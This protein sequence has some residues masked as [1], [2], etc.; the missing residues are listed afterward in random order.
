MRLKLSRLRP[1]QVKP[2]PRMNVSPATIRHAAGHDTPLATSSAMAACRSKT[3][4][5]TRKSAPAARRPP[6]ESA[7]SSEKRCREKRRPRQ[8]AQQSDAGLVS[9]NSKP[10]GHDRGVAARWNQ[11]SYL[12]L[13][14]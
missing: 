5:T 10:R 11:S 12:P 13:V 7:A 1:Y 8:D 4:V 2:A 14:R 6:R 3:I 9:P